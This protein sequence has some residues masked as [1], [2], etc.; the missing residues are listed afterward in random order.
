MDDNIEI[1]LEKVVEKLLNRVSQL[2]YDNTLLTIA[3][4]QKKSREEGE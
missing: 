1:K 3:L 2:E 4:E